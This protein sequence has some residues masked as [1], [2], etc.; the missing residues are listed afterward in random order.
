MRHRDVPRGLLWLAIVAPAAVFLVQG[1][2]ERIAPA[3]ARPG[4]AVLPARRSR[5]ASP[6]PSPSRGMM[7][8]SRMSM[9]RTLLH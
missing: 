7:V 9:V 4:P 1:L 6:L 3:G 8:S 2:T 5:F